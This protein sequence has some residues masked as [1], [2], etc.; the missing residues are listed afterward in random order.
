MKSMIYVIG[1]IT[2]VKA[3]P[4]R[5]T[6]NDKRIPIRAKSIFTIIN[7]TTPLILKL[8]IIPGMR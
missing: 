5:K 2:K 4:N 6:I 3:S 1:D 8:K 7:Q